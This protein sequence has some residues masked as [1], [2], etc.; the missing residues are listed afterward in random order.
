V[1]K[2]FDWLARA[3]AI[4][5]GLVVVVITLL[6]SW[7]IVGRWLF[8]S[9]VM[10]DTEIIEF[11]MAIVVAGCLPICQWRG[12]NI[13][14]DFFTTGATAQ[15]RERL[16]RLGSL[17]VALMMGLIGWRTVV[18][19]FD[20]KA[21]GS[22]TMLLQWP[23]WIAYALMAPPLIITALMGLYTGITGRNGAAATDFG[24]DPVAALLAPER[25]A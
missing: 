6:T 3:C 21:S 25:Q 4:V 24:D 15:T 16:D 20:Q 10:G 18:A 11:A 12:D 13:I 5:A 23:E 14:V 2:V 17:L 9:P 1:E 22:V 19:V 8:G 7:S